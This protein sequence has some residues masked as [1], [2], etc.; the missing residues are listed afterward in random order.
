MRSGCSY[1]ASDHYNGH[2]PRKKQ[3]VDA[4]LY[5]INHVHQDANSA[6]LQLG[7]SNGPLKHYLGGLAV[8][9]VR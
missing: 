5:G 2:V 9:L 3:H 4:Y 8:L 6:S 7:D 1:L